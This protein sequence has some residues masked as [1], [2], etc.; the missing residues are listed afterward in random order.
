MNE[1]L[2]LDANVTTAL[3]VIVTGV[4][5][6]ALTSLLKH[7]GLSKTWKRII[8]MGLAAVAALVIMFLQ[9][10]GPFAEQ[11]ITWL[12]LLATLIGIAQSLYAVM[13]GVWKS[14]EDN[15][16]PPTHRADKPRA[17]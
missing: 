10:G 2:A 6:P 5:I 13:P 12:L 9:A 3:T 8:P 1:L 7:P 4:L 16:S 14:L 11:L 15:T 17:S